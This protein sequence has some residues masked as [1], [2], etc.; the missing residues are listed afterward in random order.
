MII[1]DN[2]MDLRFFLTK[3]EYVVRNL[4]IVNNMEARAITD[5][6]SFVKADTYTN[7][8]NAPI[9]GNSV[10]SQNWFYTTLPDEKKMAKH[11]YTISTYSDDTLSNKIGE[12]T[13]GSNL[14]DHGEQGIILAG[15]GFDQLLNVQTF[16]VQSAYGIYDKIHKVLLINVL[17]FAINEFLFVKKY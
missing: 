4:V 15:E 12:I 17:F 9:Y 6:T 2:F 14:L 1:T 11:T 13:F 8:N 3:G 16:F 5:N 10:I 7:L